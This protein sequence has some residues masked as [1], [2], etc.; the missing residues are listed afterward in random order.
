MNRLKLAVLLSGSGTT[1]ENLFEKRAE[2]MLDAEVAVVVSS[3]AD[4]FGL[5]R[6]KNHGVPGITVE[7]KKF[8]SAEPFSATLFSAIAPYKPDLIVLAGFMS[9]LRIPPQFEQRVV[10]VHPALLPAFGGKGYYGHKVHEAVLK[11]GCKISGCTVHFVDNEYDQGPIILQKAVPVLAGDTVDALA[12]RVQEAERELYPQAI[13]LL[14]QGRL[15]I[16][17]RRVEIVPAP[18]DVAL[19]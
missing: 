15:K 6:A 2:G 8:P 11:H 7:R 1:L 5:E 14:A 17:D 3:R 16:K 4:A 10:N 12:A 9:L 18:D 19:R 13:Q